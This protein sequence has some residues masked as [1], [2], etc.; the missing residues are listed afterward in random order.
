MEKCTA[1]ED[2]FE[3]KMPLKTYMEKAAFF[4]YPAL[5]VIYNINDHRK[6]AALF[7]QCGHL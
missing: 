5:V 7:L 1:T 3:V 6:K 4:T 2:A